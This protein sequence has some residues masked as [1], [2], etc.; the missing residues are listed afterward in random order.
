MK[1]V[2]ILPLLV[3]AALVCMGQLNG[4]I[5]PGMEERFGKGIRKVVMI[6]DEN[7]RTVYRIARD[8][9]VT[10]PWTLDKKRRVRLY[11]DKEKN[12][13]V[14]KYI[15]TRYYEGKPKKV[16]VE[17]RVTFDT[18][19]GV[20]YTKYSVVFHNNY[21]CSMQKERRDLKSFTDSVFE[22]PMDRSRSLMLGDPLPWDSVRLVSVVWYADSTFSE[23]VR[24][25]YCRDGVLHTVSTYSKVG[26]TN[27]YITVYDTDRFKPK[28][29][30][31]VYKE[32][33]GGEV[34]FC[35]APDST[36]LEMSRLTRNERGMPDTIYTWKLH[37]NGRCVRTVDDDKPWEKTETHTYKYNSR[38]GIV[39]DNTYWNGT[40]VRQERYKL[41]YR[42][43]RK[44]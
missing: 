40:L 38:G 25:E 9:S 24:R 21:L 35:Y 28:P 44:K 14:C 37:G 20:E 39:E 31:D 1:K 8:G 17:L 27:L 43:F 32:Y 15:T 7:H 42:L 16:N 11:Y 10:Y 29:F 23:R 36:L 3:F 30:F 4:Y 34:S 5:V 33:P 2:L 13:Q 12:E 41:R 22:F 19:E 18:V 26:D 6:D